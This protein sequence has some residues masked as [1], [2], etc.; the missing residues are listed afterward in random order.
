MKIPS[1]KRIY[2][3][4]A[5]TG[6]AVLAAAGLVAAVGVRVN[7]TPSIPT[8]FYLTTDEVAKKGDFVLFC[9]PDTPLFDEAMHR[10]FIAAGPCPGGHGYLMKKILAAK[11]DKVSFSASGV[12]VNGIAVPNSRPIA[13]AELPIVELQGYRLQDD[14]ALLMSDRNPNSFDGR[15]W[16]ML[17]LS[18]IRAVIRPIL[19][20]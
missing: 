13:G 3:A 6:I 19:V 18:Q 15:Y 9:P 20:W 16:G 14:E 1:L 8:G 5:I 10:G 12:I 17:K 4:T 11:G 2:A 7:T